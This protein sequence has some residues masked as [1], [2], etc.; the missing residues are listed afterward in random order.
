M[1]DRDVHLNDV[2]VYRPGLAMWVAIG[3]WT[4]A[5]IA[6]LAFLGPV[7]YGSQ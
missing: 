1:G 6:F 4:L 2:P 7:A 3:V 5:V